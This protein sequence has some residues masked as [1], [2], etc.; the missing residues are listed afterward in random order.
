MANVC[1]DW[2]PYMGPTI[3]TADLEK[4]IEEIESQ[5]KAVANS[6]RLH[7]DRIASLEARMQL[8]ENR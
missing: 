8:E 3:N 2:R 5:E 1:V 4:R 6:F 7:R